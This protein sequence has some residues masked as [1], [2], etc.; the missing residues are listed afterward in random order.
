MIVRRKNRNTYA[1]LWQKLSRIFA[2]QQYRSI[3]RYIRREKSHSHK[4]ILFAIYLQARMSLYSLLHNC[5]YKNHIQIFETCIIHLLSFP[6]FI[7]LRTFLKQIQQ[8]LTIRCC[9][10]MVHEQKSLHIIQIWLIGTFPYRYHNN[11]F[12]MIINSRYSV[13]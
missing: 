9:Q 12:I 1:S 8:V 2:E 4:K 13:R 11:F 10:G 5:S 6:R 3:S 7:M